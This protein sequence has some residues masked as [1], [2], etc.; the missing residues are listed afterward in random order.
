MYYNQN[1]SICMKTKFYYGFSFWT[2]ASAEPL[3]SFMNSVI[4]NGMDS[5]SQQLIP[6]YLMKIFT[7]IVLG[8]Q[9]AQGQLSKPS[10]MG[11]G[12]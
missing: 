7:C 12:K 4:C 10:L 9:R 1:L 3:G 5:E 11:F 8:I 6:L 2:T